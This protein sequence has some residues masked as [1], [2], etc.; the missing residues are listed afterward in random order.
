MFSLNVRQDFVLT[1]HL[2]NAFDLNIFFSRLYTSVCLRVCP[3]VSIIL[4]CIQPYTASSL[5]GSG[6]CVS[7]GVVEADS[8]C[9]GIW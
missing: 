9:M 7:L 4:S 3:S 5:A 6:L 1:V 2:H 8:P